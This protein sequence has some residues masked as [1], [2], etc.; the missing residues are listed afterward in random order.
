M[1]DAIDVFRER[2]SQA[3]AARDAGVTHLR[4]TAQARAVL[5]GLSL[6]TGQRVFDPESGLEGEIIAG[7]RQQVV[8][9]A[10]E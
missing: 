1:T 4:E 5:P 8:I 2:V 10:P 9:Q 3:R 6:L 7:T